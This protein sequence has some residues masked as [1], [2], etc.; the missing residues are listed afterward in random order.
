MSFADDNDDYYGV[1]RDVVDT[2]D[3]DHPLES[4]DNP[5]AVLIN[6]KKKYVLL[7]S[8]AVSAFLTGGIIFGFPALQIVYKQ[9]GVYSWLC[10]PGATPCA[11]Q[12]SALTEIFVVSSTVFGMAVYPD[13]WILDAFGP[14]TASCF[15]A[16]LF[17]TGSAL[18]AF[19]SHSFEA[20]MTGFVM[21]AF[22]GPA[23]VFSSMHLSNLFPGSENS[24]IT[25][26]NVM[27]DASAVVFVIFHQVFTTFHLSSKYFFIGMGVVGFLSFLVSLCC[28]P[29]ESC[30]PLNFGP[31]DGGGGREL[32]LEE[33]VHQKSFVQQVKSGLYIWGCLFTMV[34]MVHINYYIATVNVQLEHIVKSPQA[35]T[36][37]TVL[38][39]WSLPLGGV[40]FAYLVGCILDRS[41]RW[42]GLL[43]LN[44]VGL[45]FGVIT[46]L[47][48]L[49][50][51][52]VTFVLVS[53]YRALLFSAMVAFHID[54]FGVATFG[55][56]WG[57]TEVV[58]GLF[59]LGIQ[60]L[61]NFT[62]NTLGGDFY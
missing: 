42:V 11:K 16:L 47:H 50:A 53:L 34:H 46:L 5:T 43:T 60:P 32:Y 15:G 56:T 21:I 48:N 28:C 35:V 18:L 7:V 55:K 20:Y 36:F 61:Y 8:A 9:E 49:N 10:N 26:L 52:I 25:L 22:A 4:D 12:N 59:N 51:Q 13:G 23:I 54:V 1:L 29:D 2:V 39:S 44:T 14:R 31:G 62:I 27:L 58:C 37:W 30:R 24:V 6:S 57:L 41:S 45:V 38:F 17:S 3:E 40:L 19:S 33:H